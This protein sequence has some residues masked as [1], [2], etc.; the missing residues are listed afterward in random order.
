MIAPRP[1]DERALEEL[2]ARC[3]SRR[4]AAPT[5]APSWRPTASGA[6]RLAELAGRLGADAPARGRRTRCSTTA[7]GARAR[8][9]PRCPT[10][11]ARAR[12]CSRRREGD[13]RAAPARGGRGERLLLDFAGSAAQHE[14][15]LNCPLAVT[16]SAC[17]FA[18]RVLTD[19]DIPPTAG[20]YRPIEVRAPEGMPAERA[21]PARPWRRATSRPP[22][23]WPTSC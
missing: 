13:L 18:L 9:W 19:P 1:L 3:A 10:A 20:A 12:T 8:A 21:R 4:S 11:F 2:V 15:N 16:R 14:G 17:L 22:R 5:C 7:S 23:A 6:P